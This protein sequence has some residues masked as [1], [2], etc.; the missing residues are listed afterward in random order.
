M[1]SASEQFDELYLPCGGGF[2][3]QRKEDFELEVTEFKVVIRAPK[4]KVYEL[5]IGFG[6]PLIG[7]ILFAEF[8]MQ[9]FRLLIYGLMIPIFLMVI[10]FAF[11]FMGSY[12]KKG[13][14]IVWDKRSGRVDFPRLAK[15]DT[16][17][18]FLC[19]QMIYDN[20][21]D[22]QTHYGINC[23]FRT[24]N[25]FKRYPLFLTSYGNIDSHV[26]KM[27]RALGVHVQK[28]AY[29]GKKPVVS[30][31]DFAKTSENE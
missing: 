9:D 7:F 16:I 11:Y 6:L 5:V 15:S 22:E 26:F 19:F 27:A 30:G 18:N 20:F 28:V 31:F 24:A 3:L 12:H 1:D 14:W 17:N 10:V 8:L 25:G 13:D 23:V 29:D 21:S 4:S 2:I